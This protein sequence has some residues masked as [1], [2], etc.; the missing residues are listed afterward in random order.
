MK[1]KRKKLG[2]WSIA[3][4][5][6][7]LILLV[8]WGLI[9]PYIL[10]EEETEAVIPNLPA[11]WEGQK[12]AQVSDF[13]V[14][15]WLDNV[16]TIAK[17]TEKIIAEQPAA[18][19][20]SGDF[21]YHALPEPEKEINE[22]IELISPLTAANIP[23][24]AVLG[25]HDYGIKN[26][27]TQPQP[28]LAAQLERALE[29]IGIQVLKNEI[30]KLKLPDTKAQ[31]NNADLYL[32]GIGSHWAKNDL[33][34]PALA[35]LNDSPR[36]VMMHN[37]DSFKAFPPYTAPFAVAGHTHGG[38][39][40]LPYLPDWSWL[41]LTKEGKVPVDG[42]SKDYGATGNHLYINRGIGFSDVPI[43]INC[44]PEITFFTL[45]SQSTT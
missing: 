33:V 10:E 28:E 27:S 38:Q 44:A 26:K 6:I 23:T 1:M 12:I 18:V 36:V 22:V 41:N 24:Y 16:D 19:L 14:G 9:E 39:I 15:M 3:I 25:N 21:I 4:L 31:V 5:A 20:I 2:L 42:W 35:Q 32:V 7:L 30:L 43:R 37:P 13:Q 11:A 34:E 40:R 29:S 8:T 45:R 17:S